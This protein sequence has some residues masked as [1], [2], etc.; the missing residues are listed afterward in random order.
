[1]E[2]RPHYAYIIP[3]SCVHCVLYNILYMVYMKTKKIWIWCLLILATD[4]VVPMPNVLSSLI[5]CWHRITNAITITQNTPVE[6]NCLLHVRWNRQMNASPLSPLHPSFAQLFQFHSHKATLTASQRKFY[7]RIAPH[8]NQPKSYQLCHHLEP[9]CNHLVELVKIK[10]KG[11]MELRA[12]SPTILRLLKNTSQ[13]ERMCGRVRVWCV[14]HWPRSWWS[15]S[16]YTN[17][18]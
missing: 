6:W 15:A 10:K 4:S 16:F 5:N 1:M 14:W 12:R 8:Y 9:I 17:Q 7:I 2:A 18:K 11:A 3:N 13:N